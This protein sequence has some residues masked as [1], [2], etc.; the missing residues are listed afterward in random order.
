MERWTAREKEKMHASE[1]EELRGLILE[2]CHKV[3]PGCGIP[4]SGI[5]AEEDLGDPKQVVAVMGFTSD[6]LRGTMAMVAPLKLI[7][8]AYPLELREASR[9]EFE[10]FDWAGEIANRLLG[11]IK[12]A[13]GV[14]GVTIEASTPR[15]LLGE[16]LQISRTSQSTICST[17]LI[18][19]D[20]W[21][22]IWFD[23][24]CVGDQRLFNVSASSALNAPVEDDLL[25]FD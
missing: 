24:V 12:G 20:S 23:A 1:A 21:V 15:V 25:F 19:D 7:R 11:R 18:S 3:L 14:R 4:I 6:S 8:R 16:Q 5:T 13:L 9:W 17:C 10:A 22:R 2:A